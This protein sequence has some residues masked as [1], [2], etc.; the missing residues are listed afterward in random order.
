MN[1]PIP[2]LPRSGEMRLSARAAMGLFLG[3]RRAI[4]EQ[5]KLDAPEI[6]I[7]NDKASR[8]A[9]HAEAFA[10]AGQLDEDAVAELRRIAGRSRH[11]MTDALQSFKARREHLEWR[12]YNRSVRLLEALSPTPR[13]RRRTQ[14]LP[15]AWTHCN[16]WGASTPRSHSTNL[17]SVSPNF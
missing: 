14:P 9:K 2:P 6:V 13:W 15:S 3:M 7:L 17:P 10:R 1:D 4:R 16:G 11:A 12:H 5:R 8:V